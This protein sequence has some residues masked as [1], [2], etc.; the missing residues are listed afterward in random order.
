[1][2]A[3]YPVVDPTGGCDARTGMLVVTG[4][5]RHQ[6]I[7]ANP[8]GTGLRSL[9]S[10]RARSGRDRYADED[11]T[12]SA[13]N[14]IAFVR[15]RMGSSRG[16]IDTMNADGSGV[17][18]LTRGDPGFAQPSWSPDGKSIP[19]VDLSKPSGPRYSAGSSMW[20]TPMGREFTR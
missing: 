17:A 11:P 2:T 12:S 13:T 4:R 14:R 15:T 20:P 10:D 8:N 19:F 3:G 7:N 9:T 6:V 5:R 1:M 16:E 18:P